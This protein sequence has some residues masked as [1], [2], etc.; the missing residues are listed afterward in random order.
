VTRSPQIRMANDIAAQ[1]HHR[2][3]AEAAEE[4]AHHIQLFWEERMRADLL[5][6]IADGVEEDDGIDPIVTAA[7]E[8]LRGDIVPQQRDGAA[9]ELG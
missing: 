9:G 5:A 6:R 8:L 2:P 1:F 3:P 7:A 4:V